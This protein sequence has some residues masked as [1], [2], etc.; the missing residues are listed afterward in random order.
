MIAG[1]VDWRD[2]ILSAFTCYF[3][4]SGK[5]SDQPVVA[6]AGYV[7]C[8]E[9]WVSFE[10]DW[11]KRLGEDGLTYWHT[12]EFN[13]HTGEF[14]KG[15]KGNNERKRKLVV[16]L[17]QIIRDNVGRQFGSSVKVS[18]IERVFTVEQKRRYSVSASSLTAAACAAAV[19]LWTRSQ[20][21]RS[22]PE[23]IFEEGDKDE[24][25]TVS[26]MLVQEG[27]PLP[28]FKPKKKR[29]DSHGLVREPAIPLQAADL[30]A[31]EIFDPSRKIARDGYIRRI[32]KT[33]MV[34]GNI[35]GSPTVLLPSGMRSILSR[36][37]NEI[38]S[39][40]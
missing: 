38:P 6:T 24:D 20:H 3:D 14:E 25:A 40:Q 31:Y 23:L 12:S 18:D 36:W 9:A 16:D 37:E 7:A 13:G 35:P 15:W 32:K 29:I 1:G 21:L 33:L 8:A 22:L 4:A 34:L 5:E 11:L 19:R 39:K 27:F 28:I 17:V 2:V 10:R 30:L 26:R